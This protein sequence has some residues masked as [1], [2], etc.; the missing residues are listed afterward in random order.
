[1]SFFKRKILIVGG[2]GFIGSHLNLR[3]Q[4]LDLKNGDD[5]R[6]GIKGK[7]DV[8]IFL[9]VDKGRTQKAY[10]YNYQLYQSLDRYMNVYPNTRVIYTS[11]AAVYPDS[12]DIQTEKDVPIPV[13]L[14]GRAKL[15]GESYVQ[16]YRWH[17][18]LRL[19]NVY[20]KGGTGAIDLFRNGGNKIYGDGSA[21]RDYVT[22]ETVASVIEQAVFK[23]FRFLGITNVSTGVGRTTTEIW[24]L[25]GKGKTQNFAEREGDVR[26]SI[27]STDK[28]ARLKW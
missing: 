1:M 6:D 8:I 14:Y 5:V 20:G 2:S 19:S 4:I 25:Y 15:L 18:I 22:V 12:F 24:N 21:V 26:C 16:Q 11:S 3:A 17:T 13:N 7:Y 9:A 10:E 27:L 23:R 28:L